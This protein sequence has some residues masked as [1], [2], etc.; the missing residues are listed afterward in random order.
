MGDYLEHGNEFVAWEWYMA[1]SDDDPEEVRR[2]IGELADEASGAIGGG[3]ML[4]LLPV[5]EIDPD[6]LD[7]VAR[8]VSFFTELGFE[9]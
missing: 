6:A 1:L 9:W 4:N 2:M 8:L 3:N 7:V 5:G